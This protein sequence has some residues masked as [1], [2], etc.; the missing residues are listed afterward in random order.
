[1]ATTFFARKLP[2]IL[3]CNAKKIRNT[4]SRPDRDLAQKAKCSE[5]LCRSIIQAIPTISI[6][7]E[8]E[9][10]LDVRKN[11]I[12]QQPMNENGIRFLRQKRFWNQRACEEGK[13]NYV[14]FFPQS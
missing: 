5:I 10:Q 1:M 11:G 12:S 4:F 9:L 6:K 2:C 13:Q 3:H 8:Q 14:M 7:G